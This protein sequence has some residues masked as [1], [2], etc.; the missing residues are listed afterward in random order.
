M[1]QKIYHHRVMW[2]LGAALTLVAALCFMSASHAS[3]QDI[4]EYFQ[5]SYDPVIFDE[6][7]IS[8][9]EVFHVTVAGRATCSEDLPVSADE[10]SITSQVIAEHTISGVTVTLNSSYTVTIKPFPLKKDE[11]AEIS[12]TV[13]LQFPAQAESGDYNVIGKI[14]EAKVKVGIIWLPV[15]EFLPQEQPM[16]TVKY[17]ASELLPVPENPL[18]PETESAPEPSLK[19]IPVSLSI[20]T[21]HEQ[22][23]EQ[24][25]SWW[26]WLIVA[27]AVAT[28]IF[29][30]IWFLRHH[31]R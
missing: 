21:S 16:C 12:Q 24:V 8:G 30:V 17:T 5:L 27:V 20:P 9:S 15:T 31:Q 19:S 23:P 10:A 11:T 13:P 22:A 4:A 3:A 7:E 29:N 2:H 1:R 25:I 14:I 28:S 26:V 18:S 6:S